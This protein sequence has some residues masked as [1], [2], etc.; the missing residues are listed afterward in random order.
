M[1]QWVDNCTN[2]KT[3]DY[4]TIAAILLTLLLNAHFHY[5]KLAFFIKSFHQKLQRLA[6]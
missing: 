3:K 2:D 1:E 5:Q 4:Q 6:L